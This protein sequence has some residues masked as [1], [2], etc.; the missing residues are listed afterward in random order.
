M[1]QFVTY[2]LFINKILSSHSMSQLFNSLPKYVSDDVVVLASVL[3]IIFLKP[4]K[5]NTHESQTMIC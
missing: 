1:S 3:D 5:Y 4:P 2:I